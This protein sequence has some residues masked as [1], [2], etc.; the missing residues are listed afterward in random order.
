MR[1]GALEYCRISATM[2]ACNID[3]R[4]RRRGVLVRE[5]DR[6][7]P[8]RLDVYLPRSVGADPAALQSAAARIQAGKAEY[9]QTEKDRA[10][11]CRSNY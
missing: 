9:P 10:I 7:R 3:L 1:Q 11:I 4:I 6:K 5:R 2:P 8:V